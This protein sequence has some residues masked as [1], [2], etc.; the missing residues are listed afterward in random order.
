[1]N[2][3]S[4]SVLVPVVRAF[5]GAGWRG[6]VAEQALRPGQG[7]DRLL[8]AGDE[9]VVVLTRMRRQWV[10]EG[11]AGGMPAGDAAEA[12][13]D[14]IQA[15]DVG[16]HDRHASIDGQDGG[17]LLEGADVAGPRQRPFWEDHYRP[18]MAEMLLQAVERRPGAARPRDGEG[19]DQ[20]LG[21]HRL[22]L[23]LEDRVCRG[24]HK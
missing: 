21:Q 4:V 15:V 5:G 20:Q 18:A 23:A 1:M 7:P 16:R 9:A 14:F 6:G 2:S 11:D 8:D 13:E 3:L 22:P 24:H 19:V 12:R 17:A 10:A